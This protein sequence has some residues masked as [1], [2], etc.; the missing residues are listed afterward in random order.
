VLGGAGLG[1]EQVTQTTLFLAKAFGLYLLVMGRSR[2]CAAR[3]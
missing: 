3:N 1:K 2:G